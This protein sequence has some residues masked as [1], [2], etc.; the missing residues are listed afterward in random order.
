MT[1]HTNTTDADFYSHAAVELQLY[2]ENDY[3]THKAYLVPACRN[4]AKHHAAGRF[5]RELGLRSMRR[6]VDAGAR[7]Y[8]LEH[9]SMSTPWHEVFTRGDRDRV[10]E[11]LLD[12]FLDG[13]RNDDRWWD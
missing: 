9:G 12:N 8:N 3:G 7:Q 13:V 1:T 6:A 11:V 2:L 5:N 4:L 10:A